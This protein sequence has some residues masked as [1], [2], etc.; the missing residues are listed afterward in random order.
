MDAEHDL[1]LI[2]SGSLGCMG[3]ICPGPGNTGGPFE[4]SFARTYHVGLTKSAQLSIT[5]ANRAFVVDLF[6]AGEKLY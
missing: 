4:P 6:L 2:R 1:L 3:T 5:T